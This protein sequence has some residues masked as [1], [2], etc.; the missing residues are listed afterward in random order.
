[1]L[2]TFL[3]HPHNSHWITLPAILLINISSSIEFTN[4]L[5]QDDGSEKPEMPFPGGSVVNLCIFLSVYISV[6]L[7]SEVIQL[8][9]MSGEGNMGAG[10]KLQ[11]L[12]LFTLPPCSKGV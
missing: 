5:K 8:V 7:I 1:M 10:V 6:S 2:S 9:N 12:G 3:G 4:N 11:G